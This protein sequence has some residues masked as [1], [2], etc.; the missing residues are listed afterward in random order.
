MTTPAGWYDDGSGRHRWWDGEQWT[1][2][3][4][5]EDDASPG[6]Q[7]ADAAGADS[8]N[9]ESSRET[10]SDA[11]PLSATP[12][13]AGAAAP[14]ESA[15]V[16]A[17]TDAAPGPTGGQ[18]APLSSA[19]LGEPA[20]TSVPEPS[21]PALD[22][23]NP[24]PPPQ[25]WSVPPAP[26][27]DTAP[28]IPSPTEPVVPSPV[29][30]FVPAAPGYGQL[31]P[32][33]AEP[34]AYAPAGYA[35][36]GYGVAAP[37]SAPAPISV[38]GLVGLGLSVI[39]VILAFIPPTWVFSWVLLGVG[40]IVSLISLFFKARKWPGV[41]GLIVAFVGFIVAAVIGLTTFVS[42]AY[43]A[44]EDPD[45]GSGDSSSAPEDIDGAVMTPTLDLAVGD[46][47]PYLES[48]EAPY[49]VPVVPCDQQHAEEV[50]YLV[51]FS[52]DAYPGEEQ[53]TAQSEEAC[54]AQFQTFV[55]I[56]Y[57]D[58]TLEYYFYY[59]T[60]DSWTNDN[61]RVSTCVVYSSTD[62]T[63]TLQGAGY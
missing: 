28:V 15:S 53:I 48:D 19:P 20:Q 32:G 14:W 6:S 26:P 22:W 4:A 11:A 2:H 51:P 44:F 24:P 3:F 62:V 42:T 45:F 58:S 18:S 10:P 37:A 43:D 23:S 54:I 46:C 7:D 47:M 27:E 16:T 8:P 56:P 59:P 5:P 12:A 41:T 21:V 40:F 1:E 17:S 57:E 63:G 33:Y 25:D 13:D 36:D 30:P 39:G 50:Y 34:G 61:D 52:G 38:L 60:E 31:P 35:P 29:P 9:A 49:E 55:G